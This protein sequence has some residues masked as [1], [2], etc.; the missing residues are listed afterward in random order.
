MPS[1]SPS[2]TV[3]Q[4]CKNLNHLFFLRNHGDN[5]LYSSHHNYYVEQAIEFA[6]VK[7]SR[8]KL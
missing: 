4:H 6:N 8:K 2:T 5:L 3:P 1:R 7:K